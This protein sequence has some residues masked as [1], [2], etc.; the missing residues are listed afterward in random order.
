MLLHHGQS[1]EH[2][3]MPVTFGALQWISIE[4][5]HIETYPVSDAAQ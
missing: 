3:Q 2:E 1:I 4:L 5:I